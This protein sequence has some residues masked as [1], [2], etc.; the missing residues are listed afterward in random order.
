MRRLISTL[1][2]GSSLSLGAVAVSAQPASAAPWVK[3]Y[4]VGGYEYA[5]RYGGR[6]G[7]ARTGEIEPGVDCPHGSTT[8]FANPENTKK[9]VGRQKW[10]SQQE[11]DWISVPPGL[12]QARSPLG[13]RFSIWNR[14]IAYRGYK[15]GIETYVNPWATDDPGQP[16]VTG[17]IG[18][19]F[20]LDGKVGANDFVSPDGEKGIDNNLYRA[21][22]CDAPWRG[23]GN[24][25]LDMRANDK[26]QEG[27]YTMVIRISGNQDP[28]NDSDA[29]VE[30]GYSPDKIVKDARAGIAVDY[31][32]RILQSAQYTKL[33]ATIKNGVVETEQV[34]HLHTPRIAW[35]YDQTGDA[36]FRKGK[37]R[38][39]IAP[40]GHSGT[41][42]IG[43][44]RNWRDLYA[45]NTFA[46]DGGQQ[47]IREHEDHVALY[48]ALRRNADGMLNA[49]TG[50]YD[51]IS[52]V[53]RIR[54][55]SA[56]VVD[57]EKPMEIPK[58][59]GDQDRKLAFDQTREAVIQGTDTRIPQAVPPGTTEDAV[60]IM[61]S[62]LDDLPS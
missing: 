3:G 35:F 21:W 20:N 17:R 7:Y 51:G 29:T 8:H 38:L 45:E 5:F 36:N 24:A 43:G 42:L 27:L 25:T 1:L 12:E 26:M 55:S 30:I 19:G 58:L 9:A 57:P 33:K 44:Y 49:K 37:I 41:G 32:Y 31:S 48:Y 60:G 15:R 52:S 62:L 40:D 4:V 39:D 16:Q 34:E 50:K 22:G 11:V 2:A 6:A 14:A 10:R 28:M 23:N 59:A 13:A 53:Y 54:M 46:Q 61:E 56:F 18:D 47:G